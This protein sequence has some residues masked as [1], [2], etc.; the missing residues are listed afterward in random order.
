VGTY[1]PKKNPVEVRFKEEK[2]IQWLRRGAQ[3][4]R[5]VRQL[6]VKSGISKKLTED[7]KE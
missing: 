1:D 2:A 6:L 5:T 3:P 4:T 7:N